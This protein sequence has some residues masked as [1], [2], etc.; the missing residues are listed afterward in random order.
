MK[1]FK[2]LDLYED[3]IEIGNILFTFFY[4]IFIHITIKLSEPLQYVLLTQL[5]KWLQ[6]IWE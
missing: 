2:E 4:N 1:H 5:P 3:Q 6:V